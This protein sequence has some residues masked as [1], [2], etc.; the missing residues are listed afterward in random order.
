MLLEAQENMCEIWT[1]IFMLPEITIDREAPLTE[2]ILE[3]PSHPVT[4]LLLRLYSFECFL[5]GSLNKAL[6]FGDTSKVQSLGP[7]AHA[8]EAIVLVAGGNREKIKEEDLEGVDLYRGCC[9]TEDQIQK[10]RDAI[11][12][13]REIQLFGH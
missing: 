1:Q 6:R 4:T 13:G 12:K 5:Y 9:M 10:Y 7:Y 8:M 11:P 2:E 3:D